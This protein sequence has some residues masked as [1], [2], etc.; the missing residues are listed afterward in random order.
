MI[1]NCGAFPRVFVTPGDV[2]G[3]DGHCPWCR[4]FPSREF[5]LVDTQWSGHGGKDKPVKGLYKTPGNV[6]DAFYKT[7]HKAGY[8]RDPVTGDYRRRK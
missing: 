6:G 5:H 2:V 8:T 1:H 4:P 7:L 3:K